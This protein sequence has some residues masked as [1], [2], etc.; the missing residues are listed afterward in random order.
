MQ[1]QYYKL[2]NETIIQFLTVNQNTDI[3]C[4]IFWIIF[5]SPLRVFVDIKF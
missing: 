1:C 2:M 4:D 3:D 5:E